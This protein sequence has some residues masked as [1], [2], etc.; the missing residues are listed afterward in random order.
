MIYALFCMD[1]TV[2][3]VEKKKTLTEQLTMIYV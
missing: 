1:V 3:K 2:N